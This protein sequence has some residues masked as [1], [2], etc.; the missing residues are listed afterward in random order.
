MSNHTDYRLSEIDNGPLERL[1]LDLLTRTDQYRGVDPQGGRGKDGGK[2]GLLL[3]GPG[4]KNVI[5]HVSRREDWKQKLKIDLG[6]AADHNRSYDTFVYVTNQ[7]ISG[8]QKPI[9][10]V[11]QPFIDEQ[12]WEIDIWDGERLRTELD[13]NHQDLRKQYLQIAQDEPPSEIAS[14]LITERLSLIRRRADELPQPIK[15]GPVAVLHVI[16]HESVVG[17]ATFTHDQLPTERVPG[18][19][20]GF[21]YENTVDGRVSFTPGHGQAIQP[22][23]VYF[24]VNVVGWVEVVVSSLFNERKNLI[25]SKKFEK[26]LGDAYELS[27]EV[28]DKLGLDGPIEVCLSLLSVKGYSFATGPGGFSRSGPKKIRRENVNGNPYTVEVMDTSTGEAMK[29]AFDRVWRAARWS[30]GSPNYSDSVWEFEQ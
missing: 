16:P 27:Q 9:P 24:Y 26:E 6:K 3:N 15:E 4:R 8:N 17:D 25:A 7:I 2:D 21:S 12:G 23:A 5:V 29:A 22:Q 19:Y 20:G 1:A 11:A 14:R 13:N 18:F 10:D 30:N 28:F